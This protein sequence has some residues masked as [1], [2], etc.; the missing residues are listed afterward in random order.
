MRKK[1]KIIF[2]NENKS[3]YVNEIAEHFFNRHF[4]T[5]NKADMDL[6]M[7]KTSTKQRK[8]DLLQIMRL[9]KY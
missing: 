1:P 2:L 3:D 4:G 7:F 6:L 8:L 5:F 9:A